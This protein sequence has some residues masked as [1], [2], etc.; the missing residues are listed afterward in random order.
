MATRTTR[1]LAAGLLCGGVAWA[2]LDQ[3]QLPAGGPGDPASARAVSALVTEP[4]AT[5]RR[6]IPANFA[7]VEGYRPVVQGGLLVDPTGGCS[8]PVPLPDALHA[9]CRQHDLGYDLLRH[10]ADEGAP[11]PAGARAAID[12]RFDRN[13]HGACADLDAGW[14]RLSCTAWADVATTAVRVNSWRQHW[15][16]PV[17]DGPL[18]IATGGFGVVAAGSAL[19]LGGLGLSGLWRRARRRVRRRLRGPATAPSSIEVVRS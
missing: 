16:T 5:A 11:L 18:S 8:S 12:D 1:I 10:A 14:G 15:S 3:L 9:A 2:G 6:A 19:G 7:R 4:A 17:L 13:L